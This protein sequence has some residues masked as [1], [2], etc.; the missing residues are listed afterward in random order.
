VEHVPEVE[1]VYVP[2]VEEVVPVDE[3][4]VPVV[5]EEVPVVEVPVV[6]EEP[7]SIVPPPVEVEAVSTPAKASLFGDDDDDDVC[8]QHLLT[9]VNLWSFDQ[10]HLLICQ[11]N[12]GTSDPGCHPCCRRCIHTRL[13][14]EGE[15]VW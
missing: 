2:E 4:E 3:E 1:E 11:G 13:G 15:P 5:E 10:G 12:T 9:F 7:V 14:Q 6:E 8:L